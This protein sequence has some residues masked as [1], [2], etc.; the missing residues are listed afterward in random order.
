MIGKHLKPLGS[1]RMNGTKMVRVTSPSAE[2]KQPL[3]ADEADL[4]NWDYSL[5]VVP[6]RRS[7]TIEV[8]LTRVKECAPVLEIE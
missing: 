7:G 2:S 5:E 6:P 1:V 8:V 3:T 4:E